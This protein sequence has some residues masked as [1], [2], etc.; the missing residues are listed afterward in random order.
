MVVRRF[1]RSFFLSSNACFPNDAVADA[2]VTD[3][4]NLP[5][6]LKMFAFFLI[7]D[8]NSFCCS[9]SGGSP[10][11]FC[12][13]ASSICSF[14][15]STRLRCDS[16]SILASSVRVRDKSVWTCGVSAD[17]ISLFFRGSNDGP[18]ELKSGKPTPD[19]VGAVLNVAS[20]ITE[21]SYAS[22]FATEVPIEARASFV[23]L[24]SMM[25]IP[26]AAK[27]N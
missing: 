25:E 5:S 8:G 20:R 4:A 13:Y 26:A 21:D 10:D 6:P 1:P 7:R 3:L 14:I 11:T 19:S 24:S 9:G 27:I 17:P 2:D 18:N 15:L 23:A 16:G 12:K 22:T